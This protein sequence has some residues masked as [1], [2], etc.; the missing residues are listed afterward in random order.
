MAERV[1]TLFPV[2][3]RAGRRREEGWEGRERL[4]KSSFI[5]FSFLSFSFCF[6]RSVPFR[7]TS[8]LVAGP[9]YAPTPSLVVTPPC[10]SPGHPPFSA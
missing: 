6:L 5:R 2:L 7:F 8:P 10:N 3:E 4:G 9:P 1:F